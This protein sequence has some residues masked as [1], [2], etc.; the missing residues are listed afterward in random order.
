[1]PTVVLYAGEVAPN[2]VVLR[3]FVN[4]VVQPVVVNTTVILY[5][6]GVPTLSCTATV[7]TDLTLVAGEASP[8]DIKLYERL[9]GTPSRCTYTTNITLRATGEL[10]SPPS[11]PPPP[12]PYDPAT[13][14]WSSDGT[15]Y[16]CFRLSSVVLFAPYIGFVEVVEVV[17]E[18]HVHAGTVCCHCICVN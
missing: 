6:D 2:D 13:F 14:P 15:P 4:D 11:P 12:P 10:V 8:S 5:A 1:M 7:G 9:A 3:L 17:E 16:P 18:E